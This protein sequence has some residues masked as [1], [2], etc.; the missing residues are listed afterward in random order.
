MRLAKKLYNSSLV[1][2]TSPLLLL[3]R[4]VHETTITKSRKLSF[5]SLTLSSSSSVTRM[6]NVDKI[7][8]VEGNF[9][10]ISNISKKRKKLFN[11]FNFKDALKDLD[12]VKSVL[13]RGGIIAVPTDTIYGVACLACNTSSLQKIYSIKG[14]D[15]AKPLA[16]SV[17]NVHDLEK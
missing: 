7:L 14:R 13:K 8:R 6:S 9:R 2:I 17:G 5:L 1:V 15:M 4:S 16:I 10:L 3:L 11:E 12:K